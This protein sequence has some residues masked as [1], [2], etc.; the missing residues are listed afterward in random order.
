VL[1]HA[2][3][4]HQP[5]GQE[6]TQGLGSGED[7]DG[8]ATAGGPEGGAR[9]VTSGRN[10]GR[11]DPAVG[12]ATPPRAGPVE[13]DELVARL[14]AGDEAAFGDLVRRLHPTMVRL[15][16]T[17]VRSRAVA[18]EVAQD[19]WIGLLKGIDAFEGRSSLPSWL[20][21]IVINRAISA[22]VRERAQVPVDTVELERHDGR[23]SADGWWVTPP[24]HWA[25]RVLDGI[26]APD[27]VARVHEEIA[28][29]PRGQQDVVTLRDVHGLTSA[30]VCGVLNIS[31]GNQRVLL[32][33]A[34]GRIRA[35]LEQEVME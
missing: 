27:L 13:D 28:N 26:V 24:A 14:R 19:A 34:R 25:D 29:L 10:V 20:F 32:H 9:A 8:C 6:T 1:R 4:R 5:A 31:E 16:L 22:G 2:V 11:P 30:E 12:D 15:A 17:R 21:R 7:E 3:S 23:F 33:R 18:E 35:A